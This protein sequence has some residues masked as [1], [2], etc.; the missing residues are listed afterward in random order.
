MGWLTGTCDQVWSKSV[1]SCPRY[2]SEKCWQKKKEEEEEETRSVNRSEHSRTLRLYFVKFNLSLTFDPLTITYIKRSP[3]TVFYVY[4]RPTHWHC[5]FCH[6]SMFEIWPFFD[7]W[8]LKHRPDEEVTVNN[9]GRLSKINMLTL[10]LF[11]FEV[12]CDLTILW[13]LTLTKGQSK[14]S[15]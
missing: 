13:P 6:L 1:R 3:W 10:L 2:K 5:N 14:R 11:P 8:P 9:F 12:V 4:P 7:L 15:P